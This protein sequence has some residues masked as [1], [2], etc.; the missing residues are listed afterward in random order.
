M[1]AREK[2]LLIALIDQR[3]KEE[4]KQLARMKHRKRR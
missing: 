4:N 3:I 1:D 2:G